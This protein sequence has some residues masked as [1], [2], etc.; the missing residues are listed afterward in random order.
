MHGAKGDPAEPDRAHF[1]RLRGEAGA[2]ESGAYDLA[3]ELTAAERRHDGDGGNHQDDGQHRPADPPFSAAPFRGP[4]PG[5]SL[6][7][8]RPAL[9]VRGAASPLPRESGP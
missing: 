2:R 4:G 7:P 5:P 8:P 1:E 3:G 6:A 9:S